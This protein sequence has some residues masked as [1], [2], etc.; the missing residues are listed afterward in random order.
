LEGSIK[1]KFI[2]TIKLLDRHRLI[3]SI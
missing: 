1:S 2:L 3:C